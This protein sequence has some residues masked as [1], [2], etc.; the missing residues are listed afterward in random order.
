MISFSENKN[1]S[2]HL[3]GKELLEGLLV[4][5]LNNSLHLASGIWYI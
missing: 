3:L 5:N 2:N 4:K 1:I